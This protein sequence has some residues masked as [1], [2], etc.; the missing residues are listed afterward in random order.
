[1]LQLFTVAVSGD[2]QILVAGETAEPA[3]VATLEAI[4]HLGP[5]DNKVT[6]REVS[7]FVQK[8]LGIHP[9]RC[10]AF[11]VPPRL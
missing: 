11:S 8:E 9:D 3:A 2:C 1:M 4:G 5:E 6:A 7:Q 10:R